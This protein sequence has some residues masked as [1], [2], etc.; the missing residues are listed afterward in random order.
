ML[1]RSQVFKKYILSY[2]AG[3]LAVCMALGLILVGLAS[4][5]LRQAEMEIYQTRLAQTSDYIERQL[6]AM[7]DIRLSVKTQRVFQPFYLNQRKTNEF[8][9]IE[10]FSRYA[11]FSPWVE[12]YYLWYQDE[13]KV[14]G[15]KCT[16]SERIFFQRIMNGLSAEKTKEATAAADS[17]LFQ[18]PETRPDV[19]MIAMPFYFGTARNPS[20]RCTL[21]FLVQ[22]SSLQQTIWR[23]NGQT[24]GSGFRLEYCGQTMLSTLTDEH[25]IIGESTQEKV[26]VSI[27]EPSI[28]ELERLVSFER[29]IVWILLLAIVL[30]IAVAFFVAW[31]NYQ[32]IRNLFAKYGVGEKATNELLSLEEML[33]NA[34]KRNQRFQKQIEEQ[35]EQLDLQH[36]WLKQQL[37]MMLITD[38]DSPAVNKMIQKMGFEMPHAFFGLCFL[39][40]QGEKQECTGLVR[41]IED[42]SD[43][44]CTLYA[45]EVQEN[46]E[47]IVLMNIEEEEQCQELLKMLFDSMESRN[48]SVRIQM[49]RLV[50]TLNEIA[51][52]ALETLNKPLTVLEMEDT[53]ISVDDALEQLVALA[54]ERSTSQA[55]ALLNTL[56]AQMESRYPSYL[57]RVYMLNQLTQ[58]M[59]MLLHQKGISI[60]A[61]PKGQEPAALRE[62]LEE[63]VLALSRKI[64]L[65]NQAEKPKGGRV[66]TYIQEHCLDGNI[67]L[68]S[69][70]EA[71]GISTKQ[72]SRFLRAEVDMTFKEYLLQLRMTAAQGFLREG[73][74]ITETA[75]RVGYFNIS[76]FI[77]SFKTYNGMTP[78]EWKKLLHEEQ[79]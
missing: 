30:G 59:M 52:S 19:L 16:Y 44:E 35:I 42:F 13:N 43:E 14:F 1:M 15:T 72:V 24:E 48:L 49:S 77:K 68:S 46:R 56:I 8:E 78:G 31:R 70:A 32:P 60:S 53:A 73:L 29:L 17:V 63:M 61:V 74:S 57:M 79:E 10:N 58:K 38:N 39:Y 21:L 54:E 11:N 65:E 36:S 71:M 7:N 5:E 20:G 37:V 26:R 25:I 41:S 6:S 12:E 33:G 22:L 75:K 50:R 40:L 34:L 3:L 62:Q 64:Q 18:V 9:L 2:L 51:S 4:V 28:T 69:T 76:H 47:Y 45:A 67:S 23:M 66:S 27:A 55:L